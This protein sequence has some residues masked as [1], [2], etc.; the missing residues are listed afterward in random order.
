M[1]KNNRFV[2]TDNPSVAENLDKSKLNNQ[3]RS[4]YKTVSLLVPD[5]IKLEAFLATIKV[6][7]REK[8]HV[9]IH[10]K[11]AIMRE[12]LDKYYASVLKQLP[13]E[14]TTLFESLL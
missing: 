2:I 14:A 1:S 7:D 11:S 8:I 5:S 4:G 10:T 6:H 12:A 3:D 9:P 13:K